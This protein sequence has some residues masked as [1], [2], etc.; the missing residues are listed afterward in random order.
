MII[1]KTLAGSALVCAFLT[2]APFVPRIALGL[3]SNAKGASVIAKQRKF[4][5]FKVA[6]RCLEAMTTLGRV[7]QEMY[8]CN[9]RVNGMGVASKNDCQA[10][11]T[12]LRRA[13][14]SIDEDSS[15]SAC[16]RDPQVLSDKYNAA[17]KDA[18]EAGNIDAQ[19]C[20]VQGAGGHGAVPVNVPEYKTRARAYLNQALE[21]GDWRAVE[22]LS[23]SPTSIAHG[24]A[25][26]LVN[27]PEVGKWET[28][29][30]ATKL[31]SLGAAGDYVKSLDGRLTEAAHWLDGDK[32]RAAEQWA[33]D[34]YRT[35]FSNSPKL[36][37]DPVPC[38]GSHL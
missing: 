1:P 31:L 26:M 33:Q 32:I 11:I 6:K 27:L 5:D 20:Y 36:T 17:V 37:A 35:R 13:A 38:L 29:Y 25:G 9:S 2:I 15:V 24:G 14:K 8:I 21:R 16:S 4:D 3:E 19:M 10:K 23:T 34:M 28:A 22:L 18:A 12:E 30:G 7:Q